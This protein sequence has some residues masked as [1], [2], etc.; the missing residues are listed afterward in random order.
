MLSPKAIINKVTPKLSLITLVPPIIGF[1]DFISVWL[2]QGEITFMVDVGPVSTA[3]ALLDILDQHEIENIDYILLTHLHLDHAG[4]IG[5]VTE[6]F[7]KTPIVCH[8]TG[9]SHLVDPSRLWEGTLKALGSIG[10]AYGQIQPVPKDRLTDS[11]VFISHELKSINTPGHAQHHV[12]Y[13]FRNFLFS[14]EAGGV[15]F[16]FA[17]GRPYLRPST[18][19]RTP[20]ASPEAALRALLSRS[21]HKRSASTMTRR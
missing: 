15:I 10:E 4:G 16:Q 13:R 8:A 18:P 20:T 19:P 6:R 14:G 7:P 17:T 12:S 1:E 11:A 5:A 9:I 21:S 2:Y 3:N